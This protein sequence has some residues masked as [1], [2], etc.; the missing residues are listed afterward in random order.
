MENSFYGLIKKFNKAEDNL[1]LK[2]VYT[3]Y[4]SL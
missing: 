4:T 3:L 1:S 2:I